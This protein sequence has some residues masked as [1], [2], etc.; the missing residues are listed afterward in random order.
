MTFHGRA[1]GPSHLFPR[2]P[3]F[4]AFAGVA[5][6]ALGGAVVDGE[7][8]SRATV[9]RDTVVVYAEMSTASRVVKALHRGDKVR[10]DLAIT[11]A[12]GAWCSV[13]E[14]GQGGSAGFVLCEYL[15]E[16]APTRRQQVPSGP[17][18]STETT[19]QEGGLERDVLREVRELNKSVRGLSGGDTPLILAV[20]AGDTARVQALL[21]QGA[22]AN[23]TNRAG[24]TA[25]MFAA[26]NGHVAIVLALLGARSVVDARNAFGE[27]ALMYAA[28]NGQTE[29]VRA[30]VATGA[31]VNAREENTLPVLALAAENGHTA[32]VQ[33]LLAAGADVNGRSKDGYTALINA[34]K[35]GH[36]TTVRALLAAG[37][38]VNVRSVGGGSS[39]PLTALVMARANGHTEIVRLLQEAGAQP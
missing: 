22:D 12:Q 31:G 8:A 5:A 11:G 13:R 29:V 21:V 30:L 39:R 14:V 10:I 35:N 25:L 26:E 4:F 32:T 37:A 1:G 36:T 16:E 2:S 7:A 19:P 18:V 20:A 33:A 24:E 15:E 23:S 28:L 27:T 17:S 34:A 38:D 9:K 6:V 3:L